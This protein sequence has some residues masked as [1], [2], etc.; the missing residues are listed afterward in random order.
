ML[1]WKELSSGNILRAASGFVQPQADAPC[2]APLS[3]RL[4]GMDQKSCLIKSTMTQTIGDSNKDKRTSALIIHTRGLLSPH[5]LSCLPVLH[6]TLAHT[7]HLL[8]PF[9]RGLLPKIFLSCTMETV[10]IR[11]QSDCHVN[12]FTFHEGDKN[13][14][15]LGLEKPFHVLNLKP[16]SSAVSPAALAQSLASPSLS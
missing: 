9:G 12:Y 10:P 2:T 14:P 7:G 5:S 16:S 8:L 3:D 6:S 11:S 15:R 4:E 1:Q 13:K